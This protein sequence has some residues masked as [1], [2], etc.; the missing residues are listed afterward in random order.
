[1]SGDLMGFHCGQTFEELRHVNEHGAEYWNARELQPLL[2]YRNWRS[3]EKA[4]KKAIV[5]CRQS[6]NEPA[7]HFARARKMIDLPNDARLWGCDSSGGL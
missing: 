2:G 3:F 1:M 5:S 7:H 6:G 4:I